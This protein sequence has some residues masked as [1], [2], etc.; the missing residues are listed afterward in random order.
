M[1]WRSDNEPSAAACDRQQQC[2]GT[3]A[4]AVTTLVI[5]ATLTLS[6]RRR[7]RQSD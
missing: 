1:T 6:A 5:G 3:T 4:V 2:R 7:R